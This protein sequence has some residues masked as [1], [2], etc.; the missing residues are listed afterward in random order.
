MLFRSELL[1]L[2]GDTGV[3]ST[4]GVNKDKDRF[5]MHPDSGK[6]IV[7]FNVPVWDKVVDTV[8][9]AARVTPE[10]RYTGWDVVIDENYDIAI[11]EG[12][13]AAEPD[14]EQVTTKTGRWPLYKKYL[15]EIEKLQN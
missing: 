5:V 14:G 1:L 13:S 9:K 12:N 8:T 7:G 2:D 15:D 3:V 6:Q 10:L 4:T 11:I